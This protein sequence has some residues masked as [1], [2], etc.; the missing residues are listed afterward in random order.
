MRTTRAVLTALFSRIN[1]LAWAVLVLALG[2]TLLAWYNLRQS[3]TESATRQFQLLTEEL[4]QAIIKRMEEHESILLGAAG[5][6]DASDKVSRADWRAYAERLRLD[7]RYPG[8]QGIGFTQM[9]DAQEL[10]AFENE[11]R[12]EGFPEFRVHPPGQRE[13][14]GVI[15]LIEPFAGRNLAAFGFDM[16]SE[17]V[18]RAAMLAAARSGQSRLSGRVTLLQET[19]GKVQPGLLLYVPVYW[20]QRPL[21]TAQQ[22]LAALRGF[23]YSPFRVHDLM[24]GI[25]GERKREL[26]FELYAGSI[27]STSE[28]LYSSRG[29]AP[30]TVVADSQHQ[31]ELFGQTW[32]LDFHYAPGYLA[33]EH[34]GETALLILGGCISLLLC[35]HTHR[36]L[37]PV[38]ITDLD[39]EVPEERRRLFDLLVGEL[40]DRLG[41]VVVAVGRPRGSVPDD[42]AR[43]WHEAAIAA[44][45]EHDVPLLGTYLATAHCV[46]EMPRWDGLRAVS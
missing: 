14:Y 36:M 46:V 45:R 41:G 13:R 29:D 27:I 5:L 24:H 26:D 9:L 4:S 31:L 1:L 35:D 17:P 18:R 15:R 12:A 38:T 25:L 8:I 44:C 28:L 22:R 16:L 34:R 21:D 33:R 30:T 43:A 19:H 37:Q 23:V 11:V 42:E 10:P 7:E 40:A 6:F 2:A 3:Q 39:R 20:Q 32:H